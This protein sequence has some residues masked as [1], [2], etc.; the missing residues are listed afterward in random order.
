MG[1]SRSAA[2]LGRK[3]D[4][5]AKEMRDNKGALNKTGIAGKREFQGAA[6][7]LIG[8]RP[9]GKRKVIN[10]RYDIARDGS[11]VTIT[12]VGAAHLVM[13]PTRPHFIGPKGFGS[14][15]AL[16][17]L[18]EGVGALRA[19]GGSAR[20]VFASAGVGRETHLASG[21]RRV[22]RRRRGSQALTIGSNLRA[23]A[24]H[25]GTKGKPV[26]KVAKHRCVQV[27][28]GI[29]GRAQ[30]TEPLKKAFR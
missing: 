2:E 14:A 28:P 19:F 9:A 29:Y 10:A 12:Y 26:F 22:S 7:G 8:T 23:Y 13:N 3:F 20:G 24:F 15:A 25:P 21:G 4:R 1:T 11:G 27:L 30:I 16:R 18:G 6:A 17:R 5:L